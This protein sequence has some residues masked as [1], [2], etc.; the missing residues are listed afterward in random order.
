[1]HA[2]N[3][4]IRASIGLETIKEANP[5]ATPAAQIF[6]KFEGSKEESPRSSSERL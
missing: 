4:G 6:H 2:D 1:M 5:L 3:G